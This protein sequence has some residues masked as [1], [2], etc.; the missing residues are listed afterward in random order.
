MCCITAYHTILVLSG[1]GD[2]IIGDADN[3]P[4][5]VDFANP[6]N[7]DPNR[8]YLNTDRP[9]TCNGTVSTVRY[10]YYGE[11]T[12]VQRT[13]R[14]LVSVYRPVDNSRYER[15][16]DTISVTKRSYPFQIAQADAYL[17][18]FNC[19]LQKLSSSIQVMEGDVIGACIYSSRSTSQLD[20]LTV[21]LFAGYRMMIEGADSAGCDTG[22]MPSVVGDR[23]QQD[24]IAKIL[25]ISAEISMHVS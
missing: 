1:S 23:L 21:R 24:S 3:T 13:Y 7:F 20:M 25:H 4:N 9:A 16:S 15:I 8:L 22:V 2:A 6:I 11:N 12:V 14:S 5:L 18:G 17:A 10:C 19:D